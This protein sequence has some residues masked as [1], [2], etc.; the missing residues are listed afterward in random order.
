[1]YFRDWIETEKSTHSFDRRPDGFQ[2]CIGR[3]RLG[4]PVYSQL[5][6]TERKWNMAP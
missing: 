6:L 5:R 4:W 3:A 2:A 1:M